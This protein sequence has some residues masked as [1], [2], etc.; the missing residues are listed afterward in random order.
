M[1]IS[2]GICTFNQPT[3]IHLISFS[4]TK[5][6]TSN[7]LNTFKT[8]NTLTNQSKPH[9]MS[10]DQQQNQ[11]SLIGGHAQYVKGAAE[12]RLCPPLTPPTTPLRILTTIS[13][14][15]RHRRSHRLRN[16]ERLRANRQSRRHRRD[17]SCEPEPRCAARWVRQG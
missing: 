6:S 12:V 3:P 15:V 13:H 9:I 14:T 10:A 5:P 11:P 4:Q 16:L 17:E 8:I 2:R 7:L 1:S